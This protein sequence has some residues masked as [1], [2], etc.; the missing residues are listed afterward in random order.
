MSENFKNS[1]S[2][3][4]FGLAIDAPVNNDLPSNGL[5]RRRMLLASLGKGSVVV[6]AAAAPMHSLAAIGTLS[7][8]LSTT[9]G[10]GRRCTISGAMSA[11]HSHETVTAT[12]G[13]MSPGFYKTISHWPNFNASTNPLANNIVNGGSTPFNINTSFST[14]FGSGSSDSLINCLVNTATHQI[15]FHWIAALLNG[16]VSSVAGTGNPGSNNYPYTAA[17]VIALYVANGTV[18]TNAFNFFKDYMETL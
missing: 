1:G 6:A 18:R 17:Q 10:A 12:C 11:I 15:E 14:L 2:E 13:G 16:T 4:E 9:P 8:T 5:A 7:I 3:D